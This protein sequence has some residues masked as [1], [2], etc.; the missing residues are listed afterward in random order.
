M[1]YSQAPKGRRARIA[2]RGADWF[3]VLEMP[4]EV[5]PWLQ[6]LPG[7]YQDLSS[8][9]F[10]LP[11]NLVL[12]RQDLF[13]VPEIARPKP[14]NV[15]ETVGS[16]TLRSYQRTGV[17]FCL[18]RSG[19][20]L[21]DDV[22]LGKTLQATLTAI[23][24]NHK[25]ILVCGPL[26]SRAVWCS[27]KG[28]PYKH[29]GIVVK[30]VK[31]RTNVEPEAFEGASWVFVHYD[32][33]KDWFGMLAYHFQPDCLIFDE[34]GELRGRRTDRSRYARDLS[35]LATVK[36]RLLL[37]ATPISNELVEFWPLLDCAQPKAWG[38]V[39]KFGERYASGVKGPYGM[40]YGEATHRQEF[41]ARLQ[42]V[43]IRRTRGEVMT[44]L[45]SRQR[46]PVAV[47]ISQKDMA[48]YLEVEHDV[49]AAVGE[50]TDGSERLVQITKLCQLLARAKVKAGT[51][52]AL[53]ALEA[54]D[55]VVVFSWFKATT[56][57]IATALE[58]AGVTVFG[59]VSGEV[60]MTRREEL[61]AALGEATGKCAFV[62]TTGSCT[63]SMNALVVASA[64]VFSDLWWVPDVLLQAEGRVHR[65]G[66]TRPVDVFFLRAEGTLD[67]LMLQ[68]L[69]E[70]AKNVE[71][72]G[73][74]TD[75]ADQVGALVNTIRGADGPSPIDS[76]ID[77]LM[78]AKY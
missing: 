32:I 16:I 5:A 15:P 8:G 23:I 67:D 69:D 65:D 13:E 72:A 49:R 6:V 37:S 56:K 21:A 34:V 3:A 7:F 31:G 10:L 19:A 60:S 41:T 29:L 28:D 73:A 42:Q 20:L 35:L 25:K 59:P 4:P 57:R 33:L 53:K 48:A 36:R 64:V 61:A 18:E 24:G 9:E 22:G 50:I 63:M 76:L 52:Q 40:E 38:N 45:P 1:Y 43:M 12:A 11:A 58:K 78:K 54:H 14:A 2:P 77:G 17:R 75:G 62:A 55:K 66:Q 51:A 26:V 30:P 68:K 74:T 71:E 70:K 44:E 27:E 39:V 46:H 47:T